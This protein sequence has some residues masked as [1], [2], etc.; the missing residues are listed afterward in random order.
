M[1]RVQLQCSQETADLNDAQ[2]GDI[3]ARIAAQ[4]QPARPEEALQAIAAHSA[5]QRARLPTAPLAAIDRR[6][7]LAAYFDRPRVTAAPTSLGALYLDGR[8]YLHPPQTRHG[9]YPYPEAL[10]HGVYSVSKSLV[11]A[12]ALF[13]FAQRYG[14]ALFDT[15]IAQHVPALAERP[16]WQGVTFAHAL[17]MATGTAGSEAAEWL[18]QPLMMAASKEVAIANI[19]RFGDGPGEPGERFHYATTHFFVLSYALQNLVETREGT[20]VRY[21]DLLREDVLRPIGAAQLDVLHTRD[22]QPGQRLPLL[23]YGAR[24]NLDEALRIA[25][26]IAAE[27][28]HQGR[29]LLSRQKVREALGRTPWPGYPTGD[30]ALHYR[31]AFWSGELGT[32]ACRVAVSYMQ[33]HG[34][35]H[36]LILPGDALVVRFMDEADDDL[37]TLV[38]AVQRLR[39][40]CVD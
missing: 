15:P 1:S 20:G 39:G 38:D 21:W 13:H 12:L 32:G 30:P 3:R 28:E 34:S 4:Y 10:R 35:N 23:G 27:G 18:F 31:H 14:D 7:E 16:E 2:I 5:R 19:A 36:V 40:A 33:G 25:R 17:N 29:Q 26:L 22:A 8:A 9:P 24:P 37:D 11:G 6:G